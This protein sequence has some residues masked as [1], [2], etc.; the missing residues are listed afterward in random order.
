MMKQ[1]TE[2]QKSLETY[3]LLIAITAFFLTLIVVAAMVTDQ[4]IFS[5]V[6][7]FSWDMVNSW[8]EIFNR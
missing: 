3:A 7:K 2:F 8:D 1:K 6:P 4:N 5:M